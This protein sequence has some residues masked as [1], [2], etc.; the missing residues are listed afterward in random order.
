MFN[1]DGDTILTGWRDPSGPCLWSFS[2]LPKNTDT[3]PAV[4]ITTATTA[5]AFSAYDLPSVEALLPFYHASAGFPVKF[6]WLSGIKAGNYTSWPVLTAANAT[7][8]CPKYIAT[9]K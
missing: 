1:P 5:D 7:K 9:K 4:P 3:P 2:L 6:A 8:Y